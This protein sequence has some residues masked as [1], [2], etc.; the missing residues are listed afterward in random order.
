MNNITAA[1]ETIRI[2][3]DRAYDL[4][5]TSIRLPD[6]DYSKVIVISPD[7]GRKLLEQEMTPISSLITAITRDKIS[8][9][10]TYVALLHFIDFNFLTAIIL[11]IIHLRK[12]AHL[13]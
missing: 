9:A 7:D 10:V 11:V 4:N 5:G 8:L 13:R 12:E 6:I 3:A 2:T 1:Q